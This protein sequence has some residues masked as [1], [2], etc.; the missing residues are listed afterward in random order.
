MKEAPSAVQFNLCKSAAAVVPALSNAIQAVAT[1]LQR[2]LLLAVW[3]ALNFQLLRKCCNTCNCL[4]SP[5]LVV[6]E[7]LQLWWVLRVPRAASFDT[8]PRALDIHVLVWLQV[9]FTDCGL[10]LGWSDPHAG[11]RQAWPGTDCYHQ[12]CNSSAALVPTTPATA[13]AASASP[14]SVST[15]VAGRRRLFGV[16]EPAAESLQD[17]VAMDEVEVAGNARAAADDETEDCDNAGL[18]IET[19]SAS[20]SGPCVRPTRL[21]GPCEVPVSI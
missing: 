2:C 20:A 17:A 4:S 19:T 3:A 12:C 21:F 14:S 9:P 6:A 16:P 13:L 15:A 1:V 18:G 11:P 10:D 8:D 5:L 7:V